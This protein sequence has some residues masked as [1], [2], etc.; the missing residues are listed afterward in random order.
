MYAAAWL[1]FKQRAGEADGSGALGLL[2]RFFSG[3]SSSRTYTRGVL[4][5][6]RGLMETAVLQVE[7]GTERFEPCIDYFQ[8]SD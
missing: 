4:G 3:I 8:F 6:L 7:I 1:M 5:A 2:L